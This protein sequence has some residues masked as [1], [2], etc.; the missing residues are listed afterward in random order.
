MV[1]PERLL[2]PCA[3]LTCSLL[4][5]VL[6]WTSGS[7]C[8]YSLSGLRPSPTAALPRGHQHHFRGGLENM[9]HDC[10]VALEAVQGAQVVGELPPAG[11]VEETKSD[12]E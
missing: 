10:S 11:K 3:I 6:A 12:W 7:A 8:C 4:R 9:K 1:T 2:A 5:F